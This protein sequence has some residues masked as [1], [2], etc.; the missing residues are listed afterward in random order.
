MPA[1]YMGHHLRSRVTGV[2]WIKKLRLLEGPA[3]DARASRQQSRDWSPLLTASKQGVLTQCRDHHEG[4]KKGV[5]LSQKEPGIARC[6]GAQ[7][8]GP[9]PSLRKLPLPYHSRRGELSFL[10]TPD[11]ILDVDIIL[12][13]S[14]RTSG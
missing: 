7:V 12:T 4:G 11:F 2:S 6:P 3:Q 1:L 13:A 10:F 5:A 9:A 14:D 8:P